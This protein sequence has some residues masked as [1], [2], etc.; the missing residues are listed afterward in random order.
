MHDLQPFRTGGTPE[1]RYRARR[2]M[3]NFF[4]SM[5]GALV[6]LV[7]FSGGCLL[8]FLGFVA[9]IAAMGG[10]DKSTPEFE[11]GSY[12][13]FDLSTNITDAPPPVDLG[14]LGG[15]SETLQLRTV[16]RA[17]RAAAKDDR[18]AGVF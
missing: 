11:R 16:T 7:I 15:N 14:P 5:L 13:V 8:L 9:A 4:T 3:K 12:L 1:S 2:R 10:S 6:A 17:L 18:I